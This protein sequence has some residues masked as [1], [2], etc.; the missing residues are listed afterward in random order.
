MRM[1]I[2]LSELELVENL[3]GP[4]RAGFRRTAGKK[5][6]PGRPAETL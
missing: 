4:E 6:K 2:R 1:V 3:I 5:K